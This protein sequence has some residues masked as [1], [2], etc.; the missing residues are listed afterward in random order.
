MT[1][2][3]KPPVGAVE[4][5]LPLTI[6]IAAVIAQL[7][8]DYRITG[9][10]YVFIPNKHLAD[11]EDNRIALNSLCRNLVDIQIEFRKVGS[12]VIFPKT[13]E[14]NDAATEL[15]SYINTMP[16]HCIEGLELKPSLR[17]YLNPD[18]LTEEANCLR[19][20]SKYMVPRQAVTHSSSLTIDKVKEVIRD[21][22]LHSSS[23]PQEVVKL[24]SP[25]LSKSPSVV[26]RPIST[27]SDQEVTQQLPRFS[28]DRMAETE[29]TFVL[30]SDSKEATKNTPPDSL[31]KIEDVAPNSTAET[32]I[33][34]TRSVSP[35]SANFISTSSVVIDG[36]DNLHEAS[37]PRR[38]RDSD[39]GPYRANYHV[40]PPT[41]TGIA[42]LASNSKSRFLVAN[43]EDLQ[44]YP[45]SPDSQPWKVVRSNEFKW[46]GAQISL[47]ASQFPPRGDLKNEVYDLVETDHLRAFEHFWVVVDEL[48]YH[49]RF[50]TILGTSPKARINASMSWLAPLG[51]CLL[52]RKVVWQLDGGTVDYILKTIHETSS[53][54][55]R[56]LGTVAQ[57]SPMAPALPI[58]PTLP[59]FEVTSKRG[60]SDVEEERPAK[61]L[62]I[63]TE[64]TT[65]SSDNNSEV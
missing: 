38:Q 36:N 11:T 9:S 31:S 25:G 59:N 32:A 27:L 30:K 40:Q 46:C 45:R 12:C 56:I 29:P 23:K 21:V 5:N 33:D 6:E 60:Y 4:H 54:S 44:R 7:L 48:G 20:A 26:K 37:P 1:G 43:E 24:P 51:D 65:T 64:T 2:R 62:K 50:G 58:V 10:P 63:S 16:R 8:Q 35:S 39:P 14:G 17:T 57:A 28:V 18:E 47:P 49:V 15:N 22:A 34:L 61:L 42:Y 53:S 41:P 55:Q 52:T 3:T 19:L 13:S